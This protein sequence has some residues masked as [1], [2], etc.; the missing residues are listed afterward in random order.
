MGLITSS[1][2]WAF[3]DTKYIELYDFTEK[4]ITGE[5]H[6]FNINN[7]NKM[8]IWES[9]GLQIVGISVAEKLGFLK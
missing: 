3:K 8:Y 7:K 6:N 5:I 4:E 1:G 2:V 9:S